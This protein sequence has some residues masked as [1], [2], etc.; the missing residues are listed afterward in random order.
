MVFIRVLMLFFVCCICVITGKLFY[1][2][3][4]NPNIY[5]TQ[6]LTS[7]KIIPERG[8]IYDRNGDLLATNKTQY[9]LY[10]EPEK[11][12]NKKKLSKKIDTVIKKGEATIAGM[13]DDS[14]QWIALQHGLSK[15]EKEKLLHMNIPGIGFEDEFVRYY[16]ESSLSAHFLGFVGKNDLGDDLG[17]FG[18][19]GF[20]EKELA[21]L[22]GFVKS[23]RDVAGKPIFVGTQERMSAENGRDIVLTIDKAVQ[24]IVKKKL[25]KGM[26]EYKPKSGCV[27]VANPHTMEILALSCL[28]DF[29][30]EEYYKYSEKDYKN[31]VISDLYEPGSTFKPLIVASAIEHEKI[32]PTDFFNE[33][34]KVTIGEFDIKN[35]D[36]KYE[37]KI[38]MTRILEKSSNVGMVYI[39]K[40]LGDDLLYQTLK[41]YQ[42]DQLTGIDIEGEV[43]GYLEPQ[44]EWYP[45]DFATATFGQ[46]VGITQLQLL[47]AFASVINGGNLMRPYVV[48]EIHDA[49]QDV[50]EKKPS[51]E[52]KLFSERTSRIMQKMLVSTV[53]NAEVS[54]EDLQ[55]YAIGG[56]TGTAQVAIQG[57][58]DASKTIASF[59]GFAPADDPQFIILVVLREPGVSSWGSETAAPLFFNI[60]KDLLVYYNIPP[61]SR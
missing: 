30:P 7:Q 60:A 51:L 47:R 16:P 59:I 61:R 49:R 34:G 9:L 48:K 45:L 15:K 55:G 58:Y 39:G 8:K 22:P 19:E 42:F 43:T 54:F 2:Q 57:N 44:K 4:I 6:Y 11:I 24:N 38:T 5:A 21:G 53:E 52:K 17:Y 14:K 1:L 12:E 46:G 3:V 20:Y 27:T 41:N 33:Q 26:K 28:P 50:R 10:V 40:M 36:D 25:E 37:G 31:P 18:I 32:K 23:E 29:N 56:K 13:I 35:W